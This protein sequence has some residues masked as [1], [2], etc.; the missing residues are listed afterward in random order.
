MYRRQLSAGVKAVRPLRSRV[1]PVPLNVRNTGAVAGPSATAPPSR[2]I[3]TSSR[4]RQD[5]QAQAQQ[6]VKAPDVPG[7][8]AQ[9]AAEKKMQDAEAS[10]SFSGESTAK[11]AGSMSTL[12]ATIRSDGELTTQTR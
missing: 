12:A 5:L 4:R 9:A 3:Q 10:A 6:R 11:W 1:P 8:G 2:S 7:L